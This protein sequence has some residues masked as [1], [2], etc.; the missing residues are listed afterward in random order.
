MGKIINDY[1]YPIIFGLI[2]LILAILLITIGFLK[3]LVL[4]V[5]T[6]LGIVIGFYIKNTGL[7][8]NYFR[9]K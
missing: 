2:A 7:L 1:K 4:V 6:G 8:D 9:K 5:V 3:T